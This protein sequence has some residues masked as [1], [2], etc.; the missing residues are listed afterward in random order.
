MPIKKMKLDEKYIRRF[1]GKENEMKQMS[2]VS[3]ERRER[4]L[5]VI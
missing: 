4:K 1:E 3:V 5:I 2:S